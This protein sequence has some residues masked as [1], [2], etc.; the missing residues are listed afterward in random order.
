MKSPYVNKPAKGA[1]AFAIIGE[2]TSQSQAAVLLLLGQ[3][4]QGSQAALEARAKAARHKGPLLRKEEADFPVPSVPPTAVRFRAAEIQTR[5]RSRY[6]VRALAPAAGAPWDRAYAN[7]AEQLY[8]K[9]TYQ[10]AAEL[11]ELCLRHPLELVRIAAAAAYF[12]LAADIKPLLR[13]LTQGAR[14]DDPLE[15]NVAAVSLAR[16]DPRNPALR[17]LI[18]TSKPKRGSSP[19]H[20]ALLVHGTWAANDPWWQPGGDFHTFVLGIRN[21]LYAAV[22]RY[23]WSGG[24]SDA[25]RSLAA[26]DLAAWVGAHGAAGLDLLAHSHGANVMMLA[27]QQGL[28]A[29]HLVLMSCPWHPHKYMPDFNNVQRVSAVRVKLD[30]VILADGGGQNFND[31]RIKQH[32]LPIWFNHSASHDPTVWQQHGI[33]AKIQL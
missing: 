22:D 9:P 26:N 2:D 4:L 23:Q 12:P 7:A 19:V 15:R 33:A 30:L 11:F 5:I 18:A 25:A 13:I 10:T 14:S 16:L 28:T 6:G 1:A 24:Y 8:K 17:K 32:V 29:G 3:Q 21:D 31:A 20:T 27:T